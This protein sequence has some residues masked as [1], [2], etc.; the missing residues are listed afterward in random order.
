MIGGGY[1]SNRFFKK[2]LD[3][4]LKQKGK[5]RNDRV[6]LNPVKSIFRI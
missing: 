1:F 5:Q 2:Y 4:D 3:Y 6:Y